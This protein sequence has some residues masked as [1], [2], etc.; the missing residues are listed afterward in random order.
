MKT[1]HLLTA[2]FFV[3]RYQHTFPT[4][5]VLREHFVFAPVFVSPSSTPVLPV[6]SASIAALVWSAWD[7]KGEFTRCSRRGLPKSVTKGV[8]K[9]VYLLFF[10]WFIL[11]LIEFI[12]KESSVWESDVT[13]CAGHPLVLVSPTLWCLENLKVFV[14]FICNAVTHAASY[15]FI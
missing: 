13:S 2:F 5:K 10:Y 11:T 7:K 15:L 8:K 12:E 1:R 9:I 4:N 3:G 14:D 6:S